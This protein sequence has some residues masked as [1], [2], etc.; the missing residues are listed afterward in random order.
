MLGNFTPENNAELDQ[1]DLDIGS[2]SPVWL[3][4]D[5]IAQGGKDGL[6][7]LISLKQM[8]GSSPHAGGELQSVPTPSGA[9]LLTAIA[10]WHNGPNTWLFSADAGGTA[11]WSF[12]GGKLT[13]LWKN[14]TGGTSPVVASGMLFV[15]SPQGGLHVYTPADGTQ[16]TTLESGSGHWETPIIVDGKIILPEGNA[17]QPAASG[18]LDIWTLPAAPGGK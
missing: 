10:V 16:I 11:A 13:Q 4:G 5:I 15:Y 2:T 3:G 9:K 14:N 6:I 8:S 17:N 7:R 1:R 12:A 18:T